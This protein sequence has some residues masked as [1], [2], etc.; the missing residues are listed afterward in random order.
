MTRKSNITITTSCY[1]PSHDYSKFSA[2]WFSL[3]HLISF[4][5]DKDTIKV[6]KWFGKSKEI[7]A[8]R[9]VCSHIE[10]LFKGVMKVN[11]ALI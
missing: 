3:I 11:Y 9:T 1:V 2:V 4:Q 5:V 6:E 7:A 8:V 10:N